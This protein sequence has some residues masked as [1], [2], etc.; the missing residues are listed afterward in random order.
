MNS[1]YFLKKPFVA[2][3]AINCQEPLVSIANIKVLGQLRLQ[4]SFA[5]CCHYSNS[6]GFGFLASV[7]ETSTEFKKNCETKMPANPTFYLD[8]RDRC[9]IR[10]RVR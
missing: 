6:Y 10:S 2:I 4:I 5:K 7:E 8:E 3:I 1:S 9:P